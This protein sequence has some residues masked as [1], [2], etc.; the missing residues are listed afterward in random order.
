M[1]RP[2]C[3]RILIRLPLA[4]LK[5]TDRRHEDRAA[6]PPGLVEP[7]HSCRASYPYARPPARPVRP[8]GPEP[9]LLQYVEY[10]SQSL[11]IEVATDADTVLAGD[12][13][14]DLLRDSRRRRGDTILFRG[15]HHRYQLRSRWIG[16]CRRIFAI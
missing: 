7:G 12:I 8:K 15:N 1:P 13:K 5:R 11:P 3:Q 4:P 9:S 6:G 2:S 14:L 10:T 16:R